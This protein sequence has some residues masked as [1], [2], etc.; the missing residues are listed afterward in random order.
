[1]AKLVKQ[2]YTTV[3]GTRKIFA[4]LAPIPKDIVNESKINPEM[5]IK[6]KVELGKIIITN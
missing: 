1:M 6:V 4:Y 3:D 2:K 5:P